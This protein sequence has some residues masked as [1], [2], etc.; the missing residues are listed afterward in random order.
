MRPPANIEEWLDWFLTYCIIYSAKYPH[1]ATELFGYI[2]RIYGLYHK[3]RNTFIWRLYDEEFRKFKAWNPKT[4]WHELHQKTLNAVEEIQTRKKSNYTY[5]GNGNGSGNG[6][7]A[8]KENTKKVKLPRNGTCFHWN[9][10]G[11][12]AGNNC[13]WLHACSYCKSKDHK[14][15]QCESKK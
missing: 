3:H 13:K 4:E 5:Q 10:N 6:K 8:G 11:C 9:G 7:G 1:S 2:K 12:K 14:A 15:A